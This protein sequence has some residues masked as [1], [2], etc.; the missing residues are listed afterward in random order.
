MIESPMAILDIADIASAARDVDSRLACLVMGPND[1]A[2]ASRA[3]PRHP[4]PAGADALADERARR[5]PR[6][7]DRRHRRHLQ[8]TLRDA[9]GFA[10]ECAQGR[11]CGFDGKMLIHPEPDRP[12]Q[13]RLRPERGRDRRGPARSSPPSPSRRTAAAASSPSRAGW[14]S[15]CTRRRPPAPWP[16]P[17]RSRRSRRERRARRPSRRDPPPRSPPAR[18][19]LPA[20]G[21]GGRRRASTCMPAST[22]PL[23][24]GAPGSGRADPGGLLGGDRRSGMVR[25]RL[26]RAPASATDGPRARQRRRR[27]RRRLRGAADDLGLEPQSRRMGPR[28]T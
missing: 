10:A 8:R 3:A 17:R 6:L 2:K 27:H 5:R 20:L 13:R 24:A 4:G 15:A 22:R 11:D 16:W 1:L 18:L 14:S 25:P 23:D 7:R 12:G 28:A 19:G 26:S 9:A 21:F